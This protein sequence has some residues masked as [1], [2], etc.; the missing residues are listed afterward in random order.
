[1][2][3]QPGSIRPRSVHR[4]RADLHQHQ[5][6]QS[7]ATNAHNRPISGFMSPSTP[8]TTGR[9]GLQPGQRCSTHIGGY[10]QRLNISSVRHQKQ[11]VHKKPAEGALISSNHAITSTRPSLSIVQTFEQNLH[12]VRSI[13]EQL[14][15]Q[16]EAMMSM[17]HQ[18][19]RGLRQ[20]G[21]LDKSI[22]NI[23]R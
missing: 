4:Y 1:M 13:H 8:S 14:D 21:S 23:S 15:L 6:K 18:R 3:M 7:L 17:E 5:S 2:L 16:N 9:F 10:T 12:D 11:V 19:L 22:S 20:R